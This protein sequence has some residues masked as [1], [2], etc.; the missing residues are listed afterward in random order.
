MNRWEWSF[1][2][3]RER[4]EKKS[5]VPF[6]PPPFWPVDLAGIPRYANAFVGLPPSG[7]VSIQIACTPSTAA[8]VA[9]RVAGGLPSRAM[10][11]AGSFSGAGCH[12]ERK[13]VGEPGS[14]SAEGTPAT[15]PQAIAAATATILFTGMCDGMQQPSPECDHVESK[16]PPRIYP[17][18]RTNVQN[19]KVLKSKRFQL[20]NLGNL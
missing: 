12:G 3:E 2:L 11:Q 17:R 6:S 13:G 4:G 9:G 20:P 1:G 14:V 8:S 7:S 15:I 10:S 19:E 18:H 16:L 5:C